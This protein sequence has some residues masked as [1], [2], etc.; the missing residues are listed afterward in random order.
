MKL[1]TNSD[2]HSHQDAGQQ[3]DAPADRAG[4]TRQCQENDPRKR[5]QAEN[6][7][8]ERK[9]KKTR[10]MDIR[11]LINH[12]KPAERELPRDKKFGEG[13]EKEKVEQEHKKDTMAFQG[14]E[15]NIELVDWQEIFDSIVFKNI[16]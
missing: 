9:A 10:I 5:K 1:D 4:E 7:A 3:D 12:Q 2:A 8:T 14:P 11:D 6:I 16:L 15:E 13:E